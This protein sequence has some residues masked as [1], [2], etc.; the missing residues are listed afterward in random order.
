MKTRFRTF[1]Y[2]AVIYSGLLTHPAISD[3]YQ[4]ANPGGGYFW[5][6]NVDTNQAIMTEDL[7]SKISDSLSGIVSLAYADSGQYGGLYVTPNRGLKVVG[8]SGDTIKFSSNAAIISGFIEWNGQP[9]PVGYGADFEY[10]VLTG[11]ITNLS[12][13]AYEYG[14]EEG[15]ADIATE[16]G[17]EVKTVLNEMPDS[18]YDFQAYTD[19][20]LNADANTNGG[21]VSPQMTSQDGTS[22]VRQ[23]DNGTVHLGENSLVFAERGVAGFTED[24][25]Y[26]SNGVLH[27]GDNSQHRTVIN[28]TLEIQDPTQPNHAVTKRYSDSS[29]ALAMAIAALPRSVD[30]RPLLSMGTGYLGGESAFA[31]GFSQSNVGSGI[32]FN[33]NLG[34]SQNTDV[35]LAMGVGYSF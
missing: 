25:M 22:I 6:R 35:G 14:Y 1:F 34:Y 3:T 27:I 20:F 7:T 8:I 2:T 5:I 16:L 29:N 19:N 11:E 30:G 13:T 18:A 17:Y 24:T 4:V 33:A 9:K 28:G 32:S 23:E 10:N 15:L 26:S 21:L 12:L 31:F